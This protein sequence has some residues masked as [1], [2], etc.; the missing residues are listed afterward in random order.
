M[1]DF[2]D[3]SK[4]RPV[5][6]ITILFA[7]KDLPAER[8]SAARVKN[9]T[10]AKNQNIPKKVIKIKRTIK[11][12]RIDCVICAGGN[13]SLKTTIRMSQ[14][15]IP[16]VFVPKT[17]DMDVPGTD[18]TVGF[19][20]ALNRAVSVVESARDTARSHRRV[21][22]VELMGHKAGWLALGAA[23]SALAD[24]VLIPEVPFSKNI[25]TETVNTVYTRSDHAVLI[26]AEGIARDEK[27]S[28]SEYVCDLFE[29]SDFECRSVV[30]GYFLRGGN[31]SAFDR[32]IASQ[33]SAAS[34]D[35][36]VSGKH[37]HMVSFR[38]DTMSLQ[39][40]SSISEKIR[41]V[42]NKSKWLTD[43]RTLG[44]KLGDEK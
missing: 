13:G 22:V 40:I 24:I 3:S 33:F 44:I 36:A 37:S 42:E 16:V 30:P 32:M 39:P 11:D 7:Q 20:S 4:V 14:D 29:D 43:A 41:L 38:K 2:Q 26:C 31:P 12:N 28:A 25:L 15:K 23:I 6:S 9:R 5:G 35:A 8:F 19:D 34:L 21:M 10:K 17:I 27:M 18:Y 1:K